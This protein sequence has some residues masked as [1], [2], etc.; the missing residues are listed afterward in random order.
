MSFQALGTTWE[1]SD[2]Q[3]PLSSAMG[4]RAMGALG[5]CLVRLMF[6]DIHHPYSRKN[7]VMGCGQSWDDHLGADRWTQGQAFL[8][9]WLS[10]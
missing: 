10:H 6:P 8:G 9:Q 1:G 4:L 2:L 7:G 3:E 5:C